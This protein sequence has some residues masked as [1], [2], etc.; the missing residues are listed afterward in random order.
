M[1]LA[2][3]ESF[4]RSARRLGEAG[5]AKVWTFLDRYGNDRTRPGISLERITQARGNGLWSARVDDDLRAVVY[6]NGPDDYFLYVGHH[7]DAYQWARRRTIDVHRRTGRLQIFVAAEEAL[8]RAESPATP[9][10][11][12]DRGRPFFEGQDDEYL[13]SLGLPEE[14][15][16]WARTVCTTEDL[17]CGVESLPADVGDRLLDLADGR[18][19]P[20]P[21]PREAMA[22]QVEEVL[23]SSDGTVSPALDD[24]ERLLA[25]PL[26]T[27]I[28]FLHPSQRGIATAAFS[29]PAKVT[30]SAGT[31]KTVVA[32]HRARHLARQGR[33]VLLTSFVTTLCENMERGLRMLCTAEELARIEVRTVHQVARQIAERCGAQPAEILGDNEVRTLIQKF[34]RG[35]ALPLSASA[36]LAEWNLVVQAQGVDDWE[37]YRTASRAGRGTPLT[38]AQRR[39]V[40]SVFEEVRRYMAAGNLTDWQGLCRTARELIESGTAPREW[41][42]VIVDEVQDLSAQA[43]RLVAA[44]GTGGPDGLLVVG[45]GGQ[46]IFAHRTSLRSAG[47]EVRGRSRVLR[48]N[49]RTTEQIRRF[50]DRIVAG[51][52]DL[53]GEV[54]L[55][56]ACRS[57]RAGE[58]PVATGFDRTEDQYDYVAEHVRDCLARGVAPCEI[59]V[60]AR[61]KRRLDQAA[62]RLA[63]AG[64]ATHLLEPSAGGEAPDA[65]H[66]VTMHRA[67]GLE[68]KVG[69][70]VDASADAVPNRYAVNAAGD[71]QDR[72][73]ALAMERQLLYVSLTRARDEV[74]VTW[75]GEPSPF[76]EP[77]L[78]AAQG[79]VT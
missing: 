66:L 58:P 75:V 23:D 59:A 37:G 77:A 71:E 8:P 69:I 53:D 68:F 30:G 9:A 64:I 18:R 21:P 31:G 36:M 54:E 14:W 28:A 35:R 56:S 1:G 11:G 42:S 45:D 2:I 57:V 12:V 3:E 78:A 55:P 4:I 16:P 26:S 38:A 24:L 32:L 15:L 51:R 74:L 50:A 7:D 65:V 10:G 67:K 6:R 40:W 61:T 19:P 73:E 17:L 39:E 72:E 44:L 5:A 76:L 20:P 29:G 70:V 46:R 52:D 60:F 43:L 27:W 62:R 13:L 49:Y 47:I 41:D 22:L 25:A 79:A 33:R 63:A 34:S 48:V